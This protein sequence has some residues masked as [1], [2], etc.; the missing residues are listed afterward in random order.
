MHS[1]ESG[2]YNKART[3]SSLCEETEIEEMDVASEPFAQMERQISRQRSVGRVPLFVLGA[4]VS[5]DRIPVMREI[6]DTLCDMLKLVAK[7]CNKSE[8]RRKLESVSAD[9]YRLANDS[10]YQSRAVASKFFG[11]LQEQDEYR[12][13]WKQ[14]TAQFLMGLGNRSPVWYLEPTNF[15]RYVAKEVLTESGPAACVSLNY[16]GLTAKAIIKEAH[17]LNPDREIATLEPLYPCRILTTPEEIQNYYCRNVYHSSNIDCFYPL[18]KLRG[19]IFNAVCEN[20]ECKY[21]GQ[22]TPIYEMPS[23]SKENGETV[24]GA[25]YGTKHSNTLPLPL[26]PESKQSEYEILV[27]CPGCLGERK[28]ELDFPG[29][30]TKEREAEQVIEMLYRYLVPSLGCVVVCGVSGRW[31]PELVKF[32]R[33]C[34]EQRNIAIYCIDSDKQP[35][36]AAQLGLQGMKREKFVH[37]ER[38]IGKFGE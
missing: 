32:L 7:D 4:G 38:D 26:E 16:D 6:F 14:F 30:R 10:L 35:A 29:Y 9:A 2:W 20:E 8:L 23:P 33:S 3:S 36:L 19:D 27:R 24:S 28:I 13:V 1:P 25:V 11:V 21:F 17:L 18:I 5:A 34:V 37:I 31:D 15:H 22:R 12:T